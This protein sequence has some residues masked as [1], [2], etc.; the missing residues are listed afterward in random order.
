[1]LTAEEQRAA[2]EKAA[3]EKAQA[4]AEAAAAAEA[5]KDGKPVTQEAIDAIYKK[6]RETDE[7]LARSEQQNVELVTRLNERVEPKVVPVVDESNLKEKYRV[8]SY[9]KTEEEWDD[10]I[11]EHPTYGTDL[12]QKYLSSQQ[13]VVDLSAQSRK[14][15]MDK[16]PDLF[17]KDANGN[18]ILDR[19][20]DVQFDMTNKKAQIA[21]E[22]YNRDPSVVHTATG[23]ELVMAEVERRMAGEKEDTVKEKLEEEKRIAE[24]KRAAEA[25]GAGVASGGG[26]PP[27][28]PKV[29]VKFNSDAEKVSAERMVASGRIASLEDYCRVRD[30]KEVAYG[31]GGF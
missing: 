21:T 14:R 5:G 25:G 4:E 26:A 2:E 28:K 11:A 23:P 3:A 9:P 27:P 6:F 17:L 15:V 31:R 19:N 8:D 1:M 29:E 10:L 13:N 20:G 12:R 7:A 18:Y 16:H 22:I 30:N 24:E